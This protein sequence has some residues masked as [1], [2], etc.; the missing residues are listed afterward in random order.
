MILF[1]TGLLVYSI[2]V[3]VAFY[4]TSSWLS[5]SGEWRPYLAAL[6]GAVLCGFFVLLYAYIRHNDELV[7]QV[8]TTSLAISCVFGL[9]TLVVSI[10]RAAIGGYPEFEGATV[11]GVM[12][13]TF[14]ISS[15]FLSWKHR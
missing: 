5:Q 9:S 13:L 15:S 6:P 3:V 12:A 4:V 7:R 14:V 1:A 8:T 2:L 11:V 10:V